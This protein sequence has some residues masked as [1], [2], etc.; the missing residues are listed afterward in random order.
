MKPL[1]VMI[2]KAYSKM[3][4]YAMLAMAFGIGGIVITLVYTTKGLWLF[5]PCIFFFW[6]IHSLEKEIDDYL[7][8]I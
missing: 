5:V 1:A 8:S 7:V 4:I 6:L 2:K 3:I